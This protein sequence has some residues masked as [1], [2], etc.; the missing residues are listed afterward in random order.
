MNKAN[1][2]LVKFISTK[3]H[4]PQHFVLSLRFK[5]GNERR[6]KL[7][8]SLSLKC[9]KRHC[10]QLMSPVGEG[11]SVITWVY[12]GGLPKPSNIDLIFRPKKATSILCFK[13]NYR[14]QCHISD[15]T[16][17]TPIAT[18]WPINKRECYIAPLVFI[19]YT[20]ICDWRSGK[21]SVSQS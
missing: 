7:H 9:G 13:L 10:Y 20:E 5:L 15:K 6:K 18:I 16:K 1:S 17:P 8:C 2:S 11:Y 12:I 19:F 21:I 3:R 14:N 4:S